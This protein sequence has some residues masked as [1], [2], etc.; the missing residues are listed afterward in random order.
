[1]QTL[2]HPRARRFIA[3]MGWNVLHEPAL[4]SNYR[5]VDAK[6]VQHVT[7]GRDSC[8]LGSGENRHRMVAR[9]RNKGRDPIYTRKVEVRQQQ[10]LSPISVGSGGVSTVKHRVL[11]IDPETHWGEC[12]IC[13]EHGG[14]VLV[15]KPTKKDPNR[16]VWICPRRV[17]KPAGRRKKS[18]KTLL[19]ERAQRAFNKS[20]T[21]IGRCIFADLG[22]CSGRLECHHLKRTAS[23][24][25]LRFEPLNCVCVCSSHH[26]KIHNSDGRFEAYEI[27][28][29]FPGRWDELDQLARTTTKVDPEEVI[30]ELRRRAA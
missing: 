19:K 11:K 12:E 20:I 17:R 30:A 5:R 3:G 4:W 21:A 24:P 2:L 8:L 7:S 18:A 25:H 23:H 27:E 1:M 22:G 16:T 9:L 28:R 13:G 6:G 10:E 14:F 15:K 29:L 26:W